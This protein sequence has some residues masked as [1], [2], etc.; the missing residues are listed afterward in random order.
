VLIDG[1]FS[2]EIFSQE[3]LKDPR[4]HRLAEKISVKE[5]PEF[6]RRFP[7]MIPCRI[8]VKTTSGE[9]KTVT[10]DYPRGHVKN[11]MTDAEIEGKFRGLAERV[12]A[13]RQVDSGLE[14]LWKIEESDTLD[15]IFEALQAR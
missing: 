9:H 11:P 6:T 12:L 13:P 7:E 2:D 3:R 8:E 1:R 10:V 14:A 15:P 5:D 4:I